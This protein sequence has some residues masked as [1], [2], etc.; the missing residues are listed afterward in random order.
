MA[1]ARAASPTAHVGAYATQSLRVVLTAVVVVESTTA[2]TTRASEQSRPVARPV[3]AA[4][5]KAARPTPRVAAAYP[6]PLKLLEFEPKSMESRPQ[7]RLLSACKTRLVVIKE[8][9]TA[10]LLAA[11]AVDKA[12]LFA[13][14]SLLGALP[15]APPRGAPLALAPYGARATLELLA[16]STLEVGQPRRAARLPSGARPCA[17][18][19][20]AP[21]GAVA[22]AA[23]VMA[24]LVTPSTARLASPQKRLDPSASGVRSGGK[25][26]IQVSMGGTCVLLVGVFLWSIRLVLSWY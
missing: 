10:L 7:P 16:S 13:L 11:L 2:K 6:T 21:Q 23:D 18:T 17:I 14:K 1:L 3:I 15:I 24:R 12:A 25:R 20:H 22:G 8:L 5:S 26:P 4:L 19:A 9:R